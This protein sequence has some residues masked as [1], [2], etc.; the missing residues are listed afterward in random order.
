MS[1]TGYT[2]AGAD[3]AISTAVGIEQTRADGAYKPAAAA[4]FRYIGPT[5]PVTTGWAVNDFWYDTSTEA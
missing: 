4:P 2:K 3:L 1:V 5:A